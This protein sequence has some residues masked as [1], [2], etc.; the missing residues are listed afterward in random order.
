MSTLKAIN[1]SKKLGAGGLI[2]NLHSNMAYYLRK[3]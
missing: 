2:V 1:I 3:K